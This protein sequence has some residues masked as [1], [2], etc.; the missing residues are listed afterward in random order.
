MSILTCSVSP[1]SAGDSQASIP[2]FFAKPSTKKFLSL[3]TLSSIAGALI[4][5]FALSACNTVSSTLNKAEKFA[6][7]GIAFSDAISVLY[8]ES[9]EAA[10][11][12]NSLILAQARILSQATPSANRAKILKENDQQLEERLKIVRALKAHAIQLRNYFVAFKALAK[13]D[14]ATGISESAKGAVKQLGA[15]EPK[16]ANAS[17]AGK[18][19]SD[20]IDPAVNFAVAGYQTIVVRRELEER[21]KILERELALQKAAIKAIGESIIADRDLQIQLEERNPIFNEYARDGSLP[22]DWVK[23]RIEMLKRTVQVSALDS[24]SKAASNLH[25]SWISLA[26]N[27]LDESDLALLFQDIEQVI[28]LVAQLKAK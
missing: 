28:Q 25:Q 16:I 4:L 14:A 13:S 10:A 3:R 24:A 20:L 9:F 15:I 18:K 27:R 8:D 19:V 21:A 7:A 12:A 26:E 23:R 22:R 2:A 17:I 1:A 5:T 6:D 11:T